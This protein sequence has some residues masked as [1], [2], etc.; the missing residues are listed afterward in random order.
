MERMKVRIDTF[1]QHRGNPRGA[2][3]AEAMLIY[4]DHNGVEHTRETAADV[5]NDTKNA[6]ALMVITSALRML[7]KPCYVEMWLDNDYIKNVIKNGWLEQWQQHEW[8]RATGKPPA[9]VELW[10]NLYI[11]LQLH[12]VKFL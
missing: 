4:I 11:C 5:E 10:K 8:K 3:H 1:I 9:N 2:G 7:N 12:K 6:L